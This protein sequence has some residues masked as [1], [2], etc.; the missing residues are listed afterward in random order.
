MDHSTQNGRL[1]IALAF[2]LAVPAGALTACSTPRAGPDGVGETTAESTAWRADAPAPAVPDSPETP[3]DPPGQD[4]RS[5]GGAEA[6]ADPDRWPGIID[7]GARAIER[8]GLPIA[9]DRIRVYG[10]DMPE[11]IEIG[12]PAALDEADRRLVAFWATLRHDWQ[13]R[14]RLSPRSL[15]D[16]LGRT[17]PDGSLEL[18]DRTLA[19]VPYFEILNPMS[20]GVL[21][22]SF[23]RDADGGR[24]FRVAGGC[25]AY[26]D[27]LYGPYADGNPPTDPAAP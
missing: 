21:T 3:A 19:L 5:A 13:A 20:T 6:P 1:R 8:S 11:R 10:D 27:L 25:V 7:E 14:E 9:R 16:A 22:I 12:D 23:Y 18:D 26:R 24:W 17:R 15:F 4:G 2:A